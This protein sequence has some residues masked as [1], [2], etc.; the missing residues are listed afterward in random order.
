MYKEGLSNLLKLVK[1][2]LA[3]IKHNDTSESYSKSSE[4]EV[5][6]NNDAFKELYELTQRKFLKQITQFSEKMTT[7]K[8]YP[9]LYCIDLIEI[10]KSSSE[11]ESNN[12]ENVSDLVPGLKPVC[13]YEEGWHLSEM[14]IVL[15]ELN[16]NFCSYL[17]RIM[18]LIKNGSLST[19]LQIFICE[20]GQKI[21]DEIERNA[22]SS[23]IEIKES[24]I[25]LRKHF[26]NEAQGSK[27]Y[28]L[29]LHRCELKNGK[30]MW[31]CKK[32]ADLTNAK[33]ITDN[34]AT[35]ITNN[36]ELLQAQFLEDIQQIKI[37]MIEEHCNMMNKTE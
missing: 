20:Q 18:N 15:S 17:T 27:K 35:T 24:Y 19:T 36:T 10:N 22:N 21:L 23:N 33:I 28:T 12:I 1:D 3:Q 30:K 6:N 26:V 11:K 16:I 9:I 32:H 5:N 13:E 25:A 14:S 8:P 31:L 2:E 37:E 34:L 29:D 4:N 7:N